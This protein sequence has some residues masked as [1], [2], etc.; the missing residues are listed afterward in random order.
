MGASESI[1]GFDEVPARDERAAANREIEEIEE[2]R[3]H[4]LHLGPLYVAAR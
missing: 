3:V 2:Y 4:D 1:A